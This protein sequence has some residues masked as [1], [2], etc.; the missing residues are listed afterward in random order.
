MKSLFLTLALIAST[1]L[2]AQEFTQE[3]GAFKYLEV[4]RGVDVTLVQSESRE[5]TVRVHGVDPDAVIIE[6]IR[7]ELRIK[8]SS[9]G[10]WQDLNDGYWWVRVEV[11]FRQIYGM[12]ASL[13]AKITAQDLIKVDDLDV[14]LSTGAEIEIKVDVKELFVDVNM[15]SV[16]EMEG[17]TR[18]VDIRTSMGA[19]ADLR[20]LEAM[21]VKARSSMGAV[22]SVTANEEF[23]GSA[24]MG[25]VIR[26]YGNP[27]KFYESTSMGGDISGSRNN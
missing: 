14:E 10:L 13:G 20:D 27:E 2:Y 17:N 7:D 25:G 8:I 22:L 9:K 5:V 6:N 15:G 23:D 26:V 16:L 18:F 19:E 4:S 24:S 3:I 12:E 1:T 21:N 11:P